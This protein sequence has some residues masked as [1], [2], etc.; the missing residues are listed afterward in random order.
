[1]PSLGC[2][3]SGTGAEGAVPEAATRFGDANTEAFLTAATVDPVEQTHQT[4]A[5]TRFS[6]GLLGGE[7]DASAGAEAADEREVAEAARHMALM[8]EAETRAEQQS[9]ARVTML[10]LAAALEDVQCQKRQLHTQLLDERSS[11]DAVRADRERLAREVVDL[12]EA[13]ERQQADTLVRKA[14]ESGN[15]FLWPML[16]EKSREGFK[17]KLFGPQ[18]EQEFL[19]RS[20]E[21]LALGDIVTFKWLFVGWKAEVLKTKQRLTLDAEDRNRRRM[22]EDMK[23]QM[24][25]E[26]RKV[27]VEWKDRAAVLEER[28]AAVTAANRQL[29]MQFRQD[30]D[31]LNAV[32]A[33]AEER[34]R[35][36]QSAQEALRAE[37]MACQQ[38][39]AA[40]E[41]ALQGLR[42]EMD[43]QKEA[44][45]R[46][47]KE[48]DSE[49]KK[50]K[51]TI[52]K[53]TS[54]LDHAVIL[55]RHMRET[56]LKAK[57]DA[58]KSVTPEKFS[59]LI[60]Q[61]EDL[62]DKLG[63]LGT[64]HDHMKQ[65]NYW[66]QA[67][68]DRSQRRLEL[69]RQFLPLVHCSRGPLGQ[70]R[71]DNAAR[72]EKEAVEA[73]P[74]STRA[75]LSGSLGDRRSLTVT[76]SLPAL[77]DSRAGPGL[78]GGPAP[79]RTARESPGGPLA[80]F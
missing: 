67:R 14:T 22:E 4:R 8:R 3:A 17:S 2:M 49:I 31:Q 46:K 59:Q 29:E 24:H 51:D 43:D 5:S 33:A 35:V 65:D 34:E 28:L 47:E 71:V 57:R 25:D 68:L 48:F 45:K 54:E 11:M 56:A 32:R 75:P 12:R 69:E 37:L 13:Y 73:G 19:G 15:K 38:N 7:E 61:L 63:S 76:Q 42:R 9:A 6:L 18:S 36:L 62:R 77:S 44:W 74:E 23:R 39:L 27:V 1:M 50:L 10:S 80:T 16:L 30:D 53:L 72:R 41:S 79:E 55:A 66:L 78:R 40:R 21:D 70:K 20:W 58:A 52:R 26:M 64:E 60:A